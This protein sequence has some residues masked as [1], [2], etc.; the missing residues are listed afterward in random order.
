MLNDLTTI[1][2]VEAKRAKTSATYW[3]KLLGFDPA[4]SPFY[5]LYFLGFWAV[6][7]YIMW[8]FVVDS[9]YRV[10]ITV[11]AETVALLLGLVPPTLLA[12]QGLFLA[13]LLRDPP[14]RL[15]FQEMTF[16]AAS[17]AHR[18][19]LAFAQFIRSMPFPM[20][21]VGVASCPLSMFLTW[22][23]APAR[24]SV[25]G[26]QAFLLAGPL[27][28]F[29][30]ALAWAVALLPLRPALHRLRWFLWLCLPL[31]AL[32]AFWLP[33]WFLWPGRVWVTAVGGTL[34]MRAALWLLG[35]VG[36]GIALLFYAGSM[37]HMPL[38]AERS[39]TY[40]RLQQFG[41]LGRVYARDAMQRIERQSELARQRRVW[42]RLPENAQ[43]DATLRNRA[44]V[45][46]QRQLP[47]S[48]LAPLFDGVALAGFITL[49]VKI[50][51]W[52]PLQTWVT[53]LFSLMVRRPDRLVALFRRDVKLTFPRQ[54]IPQ[55]NLALFAADTLFP[56]LLTTLG[57]LAVVLPVWNGAPAI[58]LLVPLVAVML[59]L[60]QALELV[61]IPRHS[62]R[63][64]PY[65]YTVLFSGVLAIGAGLM[66][67]SVL[68]TVVTL[69]VINALL[70]LLLRDSS[71]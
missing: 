38:V 25:A 44:W 34:S 11:P 26:A 71:L 31:G 46:L 42:G 43:G 50:G 27:V 49:M 39:R 14:L 45:V 61:R 40:A 15:S 58:A 32:G 28:L 13:A 68:A 30:A 29:S 1:L 70:A 22:P 33:G 4:D 3:L 55:D 9:V 21:L 60:C 57:A 59:G 36:V 23:T 5:Q 69:L 64:V 24:A 7:L 63:E 8:A 17:P 67:E 16:W 56:T 20:L 53:V 2:W 51:G 12:L 52:E 6:W 41:M 19:V 10:S 66:A 35:M 62:L 37:V 48:L 54:F 65:P 47:T 18:G